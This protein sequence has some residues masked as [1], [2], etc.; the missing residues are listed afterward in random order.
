[1]R[2]GRTRL[3]LLLV[4]IYV[5]INVLCMGL[6]VKLTTEAATRSGSLSVINLLLLFAGS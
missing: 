4:S 1:M 5:V 2:I 6:R 3:E